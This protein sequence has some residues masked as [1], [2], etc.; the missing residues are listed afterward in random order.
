MP[1]AVDCSSA[2]DGWGA[3]CGAPSF[4]TPEELSGPVEA[5]PLSDCAGEPGD[6]AS[7]FSEVTASESGVDNVV[8]PTFESLSGAVDEESVAADV[9]ASDIVSGADEAL[10][11]ACSAES[12]CSSEVESLAASESLLESEAFEASEPL[13]DEAVESE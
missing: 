10:G 11:S 3:V 12:A 6:V 9:V 7:L 13:S 8:S 2:G 4:V 1:V 5:V